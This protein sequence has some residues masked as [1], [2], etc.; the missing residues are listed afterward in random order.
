MSQQRRP[1]TAEGCHGARIAVLCLTALLAGCKLIDQRTFEP[2]RSGPS[3]TALART[4]LPKLPLVT[5]SFAF[6]DLDWRPSVQQAVIAA[7]SRKPA[8]EFDVV[9][10]IPT[11]ASQ[12]LQDQY[13]ATGRADALMV[14]NELQ[15]DG[16]PPDRIGIRF[17]GDPGVPPREVLIYTR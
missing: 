2:A 9:T 15:S 12:K 3:A 11:S 6:A 8:V 10:P 13:S 5:I 16:V 17:Q 1:A 14:A 7:E 4:N